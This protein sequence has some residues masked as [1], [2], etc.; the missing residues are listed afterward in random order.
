MIMYTL[1]NSKKEYVVCLRAYLAE[2][3]KISFKTVFCYSS[4]FLHN[5]KGELVER[6]L[7]DSTN[8]DFYHFTFVILE[9]I[10]LPFF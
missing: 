4:T 3:V 10:D 8:F 5:L 9:Q 1:Q 2:F 6:T 7:T